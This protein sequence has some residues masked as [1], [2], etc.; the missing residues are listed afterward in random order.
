VFTGATTVRLQN[1]TAQTPHHQYCYIQTRVRIPVGTPA[2]AGTQNT[3][4]RRDSEAS[5]ASP[6]TTEVSKGYLNYPLSEKKSFAD[7]SLSSAEIPEGLVRGRSEPIIGNDMGFDHQPSPEEFANAASRLSRRALLEH[8][9][10]APMLVINGADDYFV[11]KED[12]VI[13]D[14]HSQTEVYLIAGTGHRAFS[15]LPEVMALVFR[16]LPKQIAPAL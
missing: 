9:S 11:P 4:S 13:F 12:N 10:N 15:K 3:D 16:W 8:S 1:E 6:S 14:G 7:P 5:P 2:L